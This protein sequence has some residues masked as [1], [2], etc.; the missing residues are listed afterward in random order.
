MTIKTVLNHKYPCVDCHFSFEINSSAVK[1]GAKC[2]QAELKNKSKGVG[3]NDRH[4]F[5]DSV[6]R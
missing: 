1:Q 4:K 6:S 5:R 2:L 3:K